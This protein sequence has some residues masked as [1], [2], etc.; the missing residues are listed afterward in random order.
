MNK[1]FTLSFTL[2]S[3]LVSSQSMADMKND[4]WQQYKAQ[5]GIQELDA[6]F[7]KPAPAPAPQPEHEEHEPNVIIQV[8]ESPAPAP[9]AAPVV[10]TVEPVAE[11]EPSH[12]MVT[13]EFDGYVF[14]FGACKLAHRN[15]KCALTITS[16]DTDGSLYLYATNG[17]S[18]SKLFDRNGNE[19]HPATIAIGNKSNSR[20]IKSRYIAGVTARGSVEFVN[21]KNDTRSIS[22]FELGIQNIATNKAGVIQFRDVNLSL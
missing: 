18:S 11:Q 21:I 8:I 14:K 10:E 15:I 2:L 16:A 1:I 13:V 3:V 5:K 9:E 19:Y 12:S 17:G 22:M 6:Q 20:Y 7:T 4:Q